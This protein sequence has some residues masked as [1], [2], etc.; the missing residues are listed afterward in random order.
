[1]KKNVVI[2]LTLLILVVALSALVFF[3]CE[4][5]AS[6]DGNI[7]VLPDNT[8][9]DTVKFTVTF[10][11]NDG[12]TS[13]YSISGIASGSTVK[14]DSKV[15]APTRK[16]YDFI[17][18]YET[19]ELFNKWDF[20]KDVVTS[21]VNLYA[22]WELS[23]PVFIDDDN[24]SFSSNEIT[25]NVGSAT[26]NIDLS[27]KIT[28]EH[29]NYEFAFF[30]D[31]EC[32]M[33]VGNL[34]E[35]AFSLEHGDNVFFMEIYDNGKNV[36]YSYKFNVYRQMQ[37]VVTF[38]GLNG[39]KLGTMGVDDGDTLSEAYDLTVT[40]YTVKWKN[41]SGVDFAFGKGGT[42]VKES[43]SL[44]AYT[45]V[46]QYLAKLNAD[47]G[48]VSTSTVQVVF[49]ENYVLPSPV[50]AGSSFI[51]WYTEGG[52]QVTGANSVSIA[53]WHF[54]RDVT[55]IA[56]WKDIQYA[57]RTVT[58]V[59]GNIVEQN[60]IGAV[61]GQNCAFDAHKK[62]NPETD[63]EEYN[64]Y[65][66][67]IDDEK[68]QIYAFDG[69]YLGSM[70]LSQDRHYVYNN[71]INDVTIIEKWRTINVWHGLGDKDDVLATVSENLTFAANENINYGDSVDIQITCKCKE[72]TFIGWEGVEVTQKS[73]E[74]TVFTINTDVD[75][76]ARW[77]KY[78]VIVKAY[79]DDVETTNLI[80]NINGQDR[81]IF[82]YPEYVSSTND[83]FVEALNNQEYTFVG[84]YDNNDAKISGD[85]SFESSLVMPIG[86]LVIKG[87]WVT[88]ELI[89][90][91][92]SE[93]QKGTA[94]A[95]INDNVVG[96]EFEFDVK[97]KTGYTFVGITA[98]DVYSDSFYL[99]EET[100]DYVANYVITPIRVFANFY[101]AGAVKYCINDHGQ[102]YAS[103][104][105]EEAI[106]DGNSLGDVISLTA[107][108]YNGYV[109][110][111]WYEEI[112]GNMNLLTT[113]HD[114]SLTVGESNRN[115]HASWK[116][117]NGS[118]KTT[119]FGYNK[120]NVVNGAMVAE[121]MYYEYVNGGYEITQDVRFSRDKVYY[122]R[123]VAPGAGEQKIT[124]TTS[125]DGNF[126]LT[127]TATLNKGYRFDGWYDAD[128]NWV[129][130]N[131]V[132]N[133]LLATAESEYFAYYTHI[134]ND[135][136]IKAGVFNQPANAGMVGVY[137][138]KEGNSVGNFTEYCI[139]AVNTTKTEFNNL[140]YRGYDFYRLCEA[141]QE[142]IDEITAITDVV[143]LEIYREPTFSDEDKFS[144]KDGFSK[145]FRINVNEIG[146]TNKYYYAI[147]HNHASTNGYYESVELSN[148][149]TNAGKIYYFANEGKITLVAEPNNGYTFCGW[150]D[151]NG[152]IR[153]SNLVFNTNSECLGEKFTA[154][155][156]MVNG[157]SGLYI[158]K[159]NN[160]EAGNFVITAVDNIDYVNINFESTT[161]DGYQFLG[162]YADGKLITSNDSFEI[163]VVSDG[164]GG[165]KH[166]LSI[167]DD[168]TG[169]TQE[170]SDFEYFNFEIRWK[171]LDAKIIV[172]SIGDVKV[173]GY[174]SS[175]GNTYYTVSVESDSYFEKDGLAWYG[176]Y[177]FNGWYNENNEKIKDIGNQLQFT[178]SAKDFEKYGYY[179][180][181]SWTEIQKELVVNVD[182]STD[183][184]SYSRYF[185][186]KLDGGGYEITLQAFPE[187][188]Y[189]FEGWYNVDPITGNAGEVKSYDT[190]HTYVVS[191][192]TERIDVRGFYNKITVENRFALTTELIGGIDASQTK[193]TAGAPYVLGYK[194]GANIYNY[195]LHANPSNGYQFIGWY[196][197][198]EERID[199]TD[200]EYEI[201]GLVSL[202]SGGYEARYQPMA[203][204][205]S[206]PNF[207]LVTDYPNN[208]RYYA[209]D[210]TWNDATTT[211]VRFDVDVPNG[212]YYEIVNDLGE[213]LVSLENNPYS[214]ITDNANRTFYVNFRHY[215][216]D[217]GKN[218]TYYEQVDKISIKYNGYV[219]ESEEKDFLGNAYFIEKWVA[220]STFENEEYEFIGWYDSEGNLLGIQ[221]EY[222]FSAFTSD[223]ELQ[224]RFGYYKL[225][226][227]TNDKDAGDLSAKDYDVTVTFDINN[228][229]IN[230]ANIGGIVPNQ[231]L[232]VNDIVEYPTNYVNNVKVKEYLFAG[233]YDNAECQGEPY[234]FTAVISSDINLYAKWIKLSDVNATDNDVL[235]YD[236]VEKQVN[237][238][239]T[240]K[241]LYF[242]SLID[243]YYYLFVRTA[244][245]G[246]TID[247]A[248]NGNKYQ[249]STLLFGNEGI[250]IPVE[251]GRIYEIE[252][253]ATQSNEDLVTFKLYGDIPEA[254]GERKNT[255]AYGL[256]L[257]ATAKAYNGY[258]FEG[259][260]VNGVLVSGVKEIEI[261]PQDS[262]RKVYI[263]D[264]KVSITAD[265]FAEYADEEGTITLY[266]KWSK[267]EA[268]IIQTNYDAGTV[269]CAY[270]I[271]DD[272]KFKGAD[273]WLFT[274]IAINSYVFRGWY[275]YDEAN[276]VEV[277]KSELTQ[278]THVIEGKDI[279]I[280]ARWEYIGGDATEYT[281]T[282]IVGGN[283]YNSPKNV[284][285]FYSTNITPITLYAPSRTYEV[286][287]IVGYYIFEGWYTD[288]AFENEVETINPNTVTGDIRLYAK[289]GKPVC[290]I[291]IKQDARGQ[292][293]EFG[294]YPQ[295]LVTDQ[296]EIAGISD[297][298]SVDG[299]YH[300]IA[301]GKKYAK[302]TVT[303]VIVLG[304]KQYQVG[305]YYFRVEP[306]RWNV[307]S[308]D[309]KI[310][311]IESDIVLDTY[312][313]NLTTSQET[314]NGK[315]V[316][317]NNWEH[318]DLR[319]FL[320]G[321]FMQNCFNEL[322]RNLISLYLTQVSNA[323][324]K[325][326]VNYSN[327][328]NYPWSIQNNTED[329]LFA[330]SYSEKTDESIGYQNLGYASDEQRQAIGSDYCVFKSVDGYYDEVD[331]V[332][333][334]SYWL[335]SPTGVGT[336]AYTV[337]GNGAIMK[338]ESVSS[339]NC[340]IRP[341]IYIS[342]ED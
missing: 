102:K 330:M 181:A 135:Y 51:G 311:L 83:V 183:G 220:T 207:K 62:Y 37:Y 194:S 280:V 38:I 241:S 162:W 140:E 305:D 63:V 143:D 104:Y 50:K 284:D 110:L 56:K 154:Q 5:T 147:W 190:N 219:V 35:A 145:Y 54:G 31:E 286:D 142:D 123:A 309:G 303:K 120:Q 72:H 16:G 65:G 131:L 180:K 2:R 177:Y 3:A 157:A 159:P 176:D 13:N 333:Y 324:N 59:D 160:E 19:K 47:G 7:N 233:W 275:L 100:V 276:H 15:S 249:I 105:G 278:Y 167:K 48:T 115:L 118:Y 21:N 213:T 200:A 39:E 52:E 306:V 89:L 126:Y 256:T 255:L 236:G 96:A 209:Y 6:G 91:V 221:D 79:V 85:Q 297:Q 125:I 339:A 27:K 92:E 228:E 308:K 322:E 334:A 1:M 152:D 248:I 76:D 287:G 11:F 155:W 94:S 82:V 224:A 24:F 253:S 107:E 80:S 313:Y 84:W 202:L 58:E 316:Y 9:T 340:G 121:G 141:T 304:D 75:V 146:D 30:Y 281:I 267:Y 116:A 332:Y 10:I 328:E 175:D 204:E 329:Y 87:K 138:Y 185:V 67:V 227:D 144:S 136:V 36:L 320:N 317:A 246:K 342:V 178:L 294:E 139:L 99:S 53:V 71:V 179:Y 78:A 108:S 23:N 245:S 150:M 201:V 260:F 166:T 163:I 199:S 32:S 318:S 341:V 153:S 315:T 49:G 18:W 336:H 235:T 295:T 198:V 55:L 225:D 170:V 232:N 34:N 218:I 215:G 64:E 327:A 182:S 299:Y 114:Y 4:P 271:A 223:S 88:T 25:Y 186:T 229:N 60:T 262:D 113:S 264:K 28:L 238:T 254:G 119:G 95:I 40:G 307:I 296:A 174:V 244:T 291:E 68:C 151:N 258:T 196:N 124:S 81:S 74:S 156:R 168:T 109:W 111:G 43:I 41:E 148:S 268:E 26:A 261:D 149:N 234:D 319:S 335:R 184:S 97:V 279:T 214:C 134:E 203:T 44:Y 158:V 128:G 300:G 321:T 69:W 192:G 272:E 130:Y 188:N 216:Y 45:V 222:V 187:K 132:A 165:Y 259:W 257:D 195:T 66:F 171:E 211:V 161:N 106:F 252:I 29:S 301:N 326:D 90:N 325:G 217:L 212:Y 77:Q 133:V 208:V 169:E 265:T 129:S 20:S 205:I 33:P 263:Y 193:D 191:E 137:A 277:L 42:P 112:S 270:V 101:D 189:I 230:P 240:K 243:G 293:V 173:N 57:V 290:A 14:P 282:Y 206:L 251:K 285:R 283:A 17:G 172:E 210:T 239:I 298:I 274:A 338:G 22:G 237:A 310:A 312:F 73:D 337:N 292:Y 103:T 331:G 46:N 323:S 164:E 266:A 61:Y 250:R 273:A 226:F 269:S 314:I 289:W 117:V 98:N 93:A 127:L 247:I 302:V 231:V 197:T 8:Q 242:V 70:K 122:I 12:V 288:Q 86:D